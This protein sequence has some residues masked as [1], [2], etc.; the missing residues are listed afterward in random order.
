[1]KTTYQAFTLI[2]SLLVLLIVSIFFAV[3][4]LVVGKSVETIEIARF[5]DRF[6]KSL[7]VTQQ[8]AILTKEPTKIHQLYY[9]EAA[10]DFQFANGKKILPRLTVPE[11]LTMTRTTKLEIIFKAE[12]GTNSSL[13]IIAFEWPEKKQKIRYKFLFGKGHYDKEIVPLN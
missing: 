1:M 6:E 10:V 11:K 4:T 5:L 7:L 9:D 13:Q 12:T 3:P 2:E 8:E